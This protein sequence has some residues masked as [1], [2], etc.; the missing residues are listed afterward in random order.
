M[1]GGLG[2]VNY[3]KENYKGALVH[4]GSEQDQL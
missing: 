1:K 4:H 2:R 3:N